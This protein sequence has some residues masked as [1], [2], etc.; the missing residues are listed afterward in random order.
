MGQAA[1][2]EDA[3]QEGQAEGEEEDEE[4]GGIIPMR[5][6]RFLVPSPQNWALQILERFMIKKYDTNGT[7]I[8]IAPAPGGGEKVLIIRICVHEG[9]STVALTYSIR[10]RITSSN[11]ELTK[12]AKA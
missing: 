6:D 8:E 7:Y 4:D 11:K 9:K 12:V 2:Q 10:P 5:S 1:S 3:E